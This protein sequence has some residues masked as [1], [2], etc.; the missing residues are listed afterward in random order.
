VNII[1]IVEGEN[2]KKLLKNLKNGEYIPSGKIFITNLM[3]IAL[4]STSSIFDKMIDKVFC[5][6]DTDVVEKCNLDKFSKNYK[7]LTSKAKAVYILV[8]NK[9]LE[10]ELSRAL[11]INNEELYKIFDS[12]GRDEFKTKF[13][14]D[15]NL[16]NKLEKHH[17][18]YEVLWSNYRD[19]EDLIKSKEI[20]YY[21]G[22][23]LIKGK[24]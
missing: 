14:K 10:D 23:K 16:I 2:E 13:N 15:N 1:Y 6:I 7:L 18:D 19:F 5:V 8:Q 22:K 20:K 9:K 4:K 21:S 17:I 3:Q 11:K 24:K 12:E